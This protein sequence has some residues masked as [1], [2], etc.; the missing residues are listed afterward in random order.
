[1]NDCN[2]V[3]SLKLP[4]RHF[5][6]ATASVLVLSTTSRHALAA[7]DEIFAR[8]GIAINGYDPVA[9]FT[10]GGARKGSKSHEADYKG[11]T[12]RFASDE[13]RQLFLSD[14]EK[15]A[16]QYGGYCAW[17]VAQ[18]YTASTDPQAWSIENDKLYLNYSLRV[19]SQWEVNPRENIIR[20][21]QNWPAV[22]ER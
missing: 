16:P 17:A 18:G 9:Y 1:M 4:R 10:Q 22:L 12:F 20:G 13:N 14:P 6:T 11:A 7:K 21:D 8:R 15:Y 3:T 5:I 19:R 2:K